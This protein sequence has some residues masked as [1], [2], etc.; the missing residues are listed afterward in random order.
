MIVAPLVTVI[1]DRTSEQFRGTMSGMYAL[2]T[3]AAQ[4]LG[5]VILLV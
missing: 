4:G 2:G 5:P 1:A 3:A